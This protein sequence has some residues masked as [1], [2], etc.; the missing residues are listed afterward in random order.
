ML[1][2][3]RDNYLGDVHISTGMT[4]KNEESKVIDFFE[5]K[6]QAHRLVLYSCTSGYP[7]DAKDV[8]LL[9][10]SRLK[11]LFDKKPIYIKKLLEKQKDSFPLQ[12]IKS[13][14]N[15]SKVKIN[16]SD[17]NLFTVTYEYHDPDGS[18]EI[19][20]KLINSLFIINED[21]NFFFS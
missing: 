2:L 19:L 3:L 8:C 4:T 17:N 14:I 15:L 5:E 6:K 13:D 11:E 10:I 9:E 7:V 20:M 16:R 1:R 12:I 21:L 18:V